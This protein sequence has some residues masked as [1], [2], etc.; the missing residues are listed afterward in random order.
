MT[1]LRSWFGLRC[2]LFL[3]PGKFELLED[4]RLAFTCAICGKQKGAI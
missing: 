3:C 1:W 2:T 4:R